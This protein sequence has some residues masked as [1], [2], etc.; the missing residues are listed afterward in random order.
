[1]ANLE[2]MS[3]KIYIKEGT[4]D[5]VEWSYVT[6]ET[7][8]ENGDYTLSGL[9][10]GTYRIKVSDPEGDHLTEYY[11]DASTLETATDIIIGD[12]ETVSDVNIILGP[13]SYISGKVTDL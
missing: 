11:A 13:S 6:S 10:P 3:I 5:D 2:G 8:D 1:M 7:T 12:N 9:G 4:G